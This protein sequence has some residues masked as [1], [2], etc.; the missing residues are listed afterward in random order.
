MTPKEIYDAYCK[1]PEAEKNRVLDYL[2]GLQPADDGLFA[3]P[4]LTTRFKKIAGESF[5]ARNELNKKSVN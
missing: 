4:E 3:N 5:T 2:R 1:L